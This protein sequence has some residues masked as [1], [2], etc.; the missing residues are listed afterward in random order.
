MEQEGFREQ[1]M[2][3]MIRTVSR[4][5]GRYV[6]A[7]DEEMSIAMEAFWEASRRYDAKKGPFP[8]F[9]ELVIESRLKNY[10]KK[11]EKEAGEVSLEMLLENGIEFSDPREGEE[12]LKDE[13]ALYRW[14]LQ[15]FSL[16]LDLL[17]DHAP[18]HQDTKRR[19]VKIA[20]ESSKEEKIVGK[21][22]RKKKLPIRDVASHCSVSEKIVKGSK[23][24]IL[25]ALII[26][27]KKYPCLMNWLREARWNDV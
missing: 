8:P 13:I 12:S 7:G 25:G 9:A 6:R 11:K 26:F 1:D 2:A 3:L 14:E 19:A 10:F 18:K 17:A 24:F 20:R 16:S 22:Y 27:V 4:M 23:H 21:T 5:T 15:K